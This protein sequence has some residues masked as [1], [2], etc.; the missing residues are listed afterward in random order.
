MDSSHFNF[1]AMGTMLMVLGVA[2]TALGV[3]GF[4]RVFSAGRGEAWRMV[5]FGL[6]NALYGYGTRSR[7]SWEEPPS[8]IAWL[9]VVCMVAPVTFVMVRW[10]YGRFACTVGHLRDGSRR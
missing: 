1:G 6:G 3:I 5:L 2:M 9:G 4:L 8:A 10:L 7:Q